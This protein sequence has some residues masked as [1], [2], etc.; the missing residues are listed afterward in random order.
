MYYC[1]Y[2]D[3]PAKINIRDGNDPRVSFKGKKITSQKTGLNMEKRTVGQ[4][5]TNYKNP[6]P[7]HYKKQKADGLVHRSYIKGSEKFSKHKRVVDFKRFAMGME[8]FTVKGI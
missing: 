5:N 8:E 3:G 2:G 6:G 7:A 1:K 4:P